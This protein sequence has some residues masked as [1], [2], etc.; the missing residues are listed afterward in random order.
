MDENGNILAG[1]S[2]LTSALSIVKIVPGKSIGSTLRTPMEMDWKTQLNA[3]SLSSMQ[4]SPDICIDSNNRY[5]YATTSVLY[6]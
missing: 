4:Q 6:Q 3:D 5:V 1:I 2:F